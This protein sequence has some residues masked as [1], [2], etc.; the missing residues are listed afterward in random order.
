VNKRS[1]FLSLLQIGA[2]LLIVAAHSGVRGTQVGQV[3]VELFF[4]I[5]GLNMARYVDRYQ[6]LAS[7]LWSRV[8]R[9]IPEILVVWCVTLFAF[10]LG[11]GNVGV[12][13]FLITILLFL[14]NFAEPYLR[15][16]PGVDWVFLAALW[17]VAALLQLQVLL[18]L[19]RKA[20]TR[21]RPLTLVCV[22]MFIGIAFRALV[23]ALHGGITRNLEYSSSDAIYR[24]AVSHI[25]P[26]ALGFMLGR[27]LLPKIGRWLPVIAAITAAIGA[28]NLFAE[29]RIAISSFGFPI[30]MTFNYQYLWGYPVVALFLT[31]LCASNSCVAT[32]IERVEVPRS[33]DHLVDRLARLTYGVYIFHGLFLAIVGYGLWSYGISKTS[34][35]RIVLFVASGSMAFFTA[36][37]FQ[38]CRKWFRCRMCDGYP[39]LVR[40]APRQLPA[41]CIAC[42]HLA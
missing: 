23:A 41:R 9:L 40:S 18:F 5:A 19:L 36:W 3:A 11:M 6:T 33:V 21:F 4:V 12:G 15:L 26:I 25:S 32:I 39:M 2:I 31:S 16:M 37:S 13:V 35:I 17:F 27:G 24:M 30:E 42:R 7:F 29:P 8:Q 20:F 28:V 14:E 38:Q 10:L 34:S 1:R 22:T